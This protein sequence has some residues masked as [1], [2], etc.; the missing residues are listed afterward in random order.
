[1][2]EFLKDLFRY[3]SSSTAHASVAAGVAAIFFKGEKDMVFGDGA[4]GLNGGVSFVAV[5]SLTSLGL[6]VL[7]QLV[8]ESNWTPEVFR[9]SPKLIAFP[10]VLGL[11]MFPVTAE[12]IDSGEAWLT[13]QV[14]DRTSEFF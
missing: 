8:S 3:V 12:F 11:Y 6:G 14:K 1:M 10:M 13:Q 4:G 2:A 9:L 5:R 7:A